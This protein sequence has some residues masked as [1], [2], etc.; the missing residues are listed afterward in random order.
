MALAQAEGIEWHEN[1]REDW[2]DRKYLS[3]DWNEPDHDVWDWFGAA[4]A[5][6]HDD[7]APGVSG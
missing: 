2:H 4:V 3:K 5:G 7:N 6:Q 1:D